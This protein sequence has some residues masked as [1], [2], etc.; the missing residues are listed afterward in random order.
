MTFLRTIANLF[1]EF[2]KLHHL[3]AW[4]FQIEL[5]SNQHNFVKVSR[6]AVVWI[7][8]KLRNSE[9]TKLH[10]N[11][12]FDMFAV[13]T[14]MWGPVASTGTSPTT[15]RPVPRPLT[16]G[17][18]RIWNSC[19]HRKSWKRAT[20]VAKLAVLGSSSTSL[21]NATRLSSAHST[22]SLKLY[23]GIPWKESNSGMP[24]AMSSS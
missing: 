24:D 16:A 17:P 20:T 6:K 4:V 2:T 15:R 22:G 13:N 19:P 5:Q 8:H 3:N 12:V 21:D 23:S 7:Y 14:R 11:H 9:L 10:I 18:G 1:W